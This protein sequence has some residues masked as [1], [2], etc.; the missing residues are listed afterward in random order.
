MNISEPREVVQIARVE[1]ASRIKE[2]VARGFPR[3]SGVHRY[4]KS[5]QA[6]VIASESLTDISGCPALFAQK[7]GQ[8]VV[9]DSLGLGSFHKRLKCF[10]P[11]GLFHG[12][13][14]AP[15]VDF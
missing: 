3:A 6:L 5:R 9:R 4:R 15:Q 2:C 12:F 8:T 11:V 10:R 1:K 14:L 13:I 7:A